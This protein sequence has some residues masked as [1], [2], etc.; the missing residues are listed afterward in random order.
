MNTFYANPPGATAAPSIFTPSELILLHGQEFAGKGHPMDMVE[1]LVPKEMVSASQLGSAIMA[2]A[3]LINEQLGC[4]RFELRT[5]KILILTR[6]SL[7]ALPGPTPFNWPPGTLEDRI[8]RTVFGGPRTVKDL[9]A[10]VLTG[11][12][13]LPWELAA[14]VVKEG[15]ATRGLVSVQK[16]GFAM[17]AT[18]HF[19]LPEQTRALAAQTP[20]EPIRQLIVWCQQTRADFWAK[21]ANEMGDGVKTH[22]P[23]VESADD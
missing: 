9:V 12:S 2:T 11:V 5:H 17:F 7:F 16:K 1:L 21:L 14:R 6:E 15:L 10:Q 23:E 4:I 22:Y 13:Y 18:Q 20:S 19:I 8:L 3:L